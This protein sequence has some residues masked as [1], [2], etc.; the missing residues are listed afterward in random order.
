MPRLIANGVNRRVTIFLT[1][2]GEDF[3]GQANCQN[4]QNNLDKMDKIETALRQAWHD[5]QAADFSLLQ[6]LEDY[7]G[8][9]D[10]SAR[11]S[12]A[13]TISKLTQISVNLDR[14]KTQLKR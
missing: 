1:R 9:G 4:T 10:F 14:L 7:T 12:V 5:L 2:S 3:F 8:E 11:Q 13:D 6:A